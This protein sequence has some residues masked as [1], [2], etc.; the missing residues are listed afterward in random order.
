MF[1]RIRLRTND[2]V[3]SR[4]FYDAVMPALGCANEDA[5][6]GYAAHG[7]PENIGGGHNVSGRCY[8]QMV[9]S[10][11]RATESTPHC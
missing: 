6:D 5:G 3:A 1:S 4:R 8:K 2:L 11:T 9:N 7:L 10:Q